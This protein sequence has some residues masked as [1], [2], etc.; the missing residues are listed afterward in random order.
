MVSAVRVRAYSPDFQLFPGKYR[1]DRTMIL[2]FDGRCVGLGT[3]GALS[4]Y[5]WLIQNGDELLRTGKGVAAQGEEAT[6]FVGEYAGVINGLRALLPIEGVEAVEVRGDA[7]VVIRQLT[8]VYG[9][10][11]PHL[12][13]LYE[14][15]KELARR[16][17]VTGCAV[18]FRWIPR[19]ENVEAD[20]L[21]REAC[22]AARERL[23]AGDDYAGAG[24]PL[25]SGLPG[26][27]G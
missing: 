14:E 2:Y 17:E 15:T 1:E 22:R 10:Y 27:K 18:T 5:G 4:T 13:P 12:I 6:S 3:P 23:E 19:E 26:A 20:A 16:L 21:S 11:A 8:G 9:C 25:A 24:D 7:Q